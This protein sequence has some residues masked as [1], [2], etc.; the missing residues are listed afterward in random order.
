MKEHRYYV[1]NSA[2]IRHWVMD[3]EEKNDPVPFDTEQQ[4]V[5]DAAQKNIWDR[6]EKEA[7]R[8]RLALLDAEEEFERDPETFYAAVRFYD[9]LVA[10]RAGRTT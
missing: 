6:E 9:T 4:A 8:H 2:K 5:D 1:L 7:D 10:E 3:K